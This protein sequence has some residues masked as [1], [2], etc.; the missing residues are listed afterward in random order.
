MQQ[1]PFYEA[2]GANISRLRQM[3][4]LT[5]QQLAEKVGLTRTSITNIEKGRQPVQAH[6]LV[7]LARALRTTVTELLPHTDDV[8]AASLPSSLDEEQ[9][10][11]VKKILDIT[12]T[13]G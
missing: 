1:G 7:A 13:K 2:F 6:V 5:Q 4:N 10:H 8:P 3:A 9:Q 11:W 12:P